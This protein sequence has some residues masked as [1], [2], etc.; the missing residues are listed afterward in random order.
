ML[1]YAVFYFMLF[2]FFVSTFA[3]TQDSNPILFLEMCITGISSFMYYLFLHKMD[4]PHTISLLRYKGWLLTTPLMLVALHTFLHSTVSL[5]YLIGLDWLMLLAG[6][7]GEL[8]LL[9]RITAMVTGFIPFFLLF[10]AL[11]STATFTAFTYAL[12]WVYFA[13]WSGYGLAYLCKESIKNTVTNVLDALAKAV[14]AISVSL[15]FVYP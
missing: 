15:Y 2:A 10:Y 5:V 12:F 14:V 6:Y 7:L 8:H 13:V 3:F 4:T 1:F 9:S 11:Y